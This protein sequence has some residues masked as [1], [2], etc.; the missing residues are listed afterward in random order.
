M[1]WTTS[2]RTSKNHPVY[3][4]NYFHGLRRNSGGDINEINT[5]QITAFNTYCSAWVTGFSDGTITAVRA[6]PNGA[7]GAA[8]LRSSPVYATHRDFPS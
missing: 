4:F 6:G 3:L 5:T 1:R 2:A 7:T 8:D